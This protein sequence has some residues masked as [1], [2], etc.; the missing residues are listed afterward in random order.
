VL[1]VDDSP[2]FLEQASAWL[3]REND[4]EVVGS[5][6]SA[7]EAIPLVER[8]KPRIVLMDIVMPGMNGIEATRRLKLL[9]NA[10]AVL[11]LTLHGDPAYRAATAAAG[12][13]GFLCKSDF[14][15]ELLPCLRR[16]GC[17]TAATDTDERGDA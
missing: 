11:I 14:A 13:E 6:G 16:V 5:V 17:A 7:A 3:S 2:L 1:L 8:L 12:A 9:P 10:P 15:T 4:I